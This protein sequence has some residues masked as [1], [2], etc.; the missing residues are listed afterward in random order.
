MVAQKHILLI[1]S[2]SIAAYKSLELI[3][4]LRDSGVRCTCV[5]T[6]GG[7]Q[8]VTPLSVASL[9]GQPVY[10]DLFSLKDETEM[11]H[12]R[13]SREADL[14]V[15]APASAD[16]LARMTQGMAHDL[17][18]TLLLA[19][20]KPVVAVP[21]M[22]T[23]MWH[24]PATQRNV[25]QLQQDGIHFIGPVS[26]DLA[27]GET[28]L[29]R[30]AE[31]PTIAQ[32]LLALLGH[33]NPQAQPLAGR[34]ALVTAGPTHEPID[35]V[36]FIGNH[37][38]GKQGYAIAE[39]LA[40]AGALVTLISGPTSLPC[41]PNVSR[42]LV[43]TAAE[44]LDACENSL[45]ADIFVGAA[46][47]ADWT[48]QQAHSQKLKKRQNQEAPSL[49][50]KETKDILKHISQLKKHRP[51]LVIGF[52]AETLEGEALLQEAAKKRL[53][54][55]CDWLVANNVKGGALFGSDRTEATLITPEETIH[56]P[57]SSKHELA[58]LL[59]ERIIFALSIPSK[60]L[61][62]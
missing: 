53:T 54:K 44:M 58:V 59:T 60:E 52:A 45:P 4:L 32:E 25:R 20:D 9:S 19:T 42:S 47:V 33:S 41:P 5:I 40:N 10:T 23:H 61:S 31:V 27:C 36:R 56:F 22:N 51:R 62:A 21:A 35:P 39:A 30:M 13:L 26:G 1:I 48:P 46:A 43:S 17:A 18:T 3:R 7:Q 55:G 37:S 50:L 8:F 16:L 49:T 14:V 38:S 12:I 57:P 24:H 29:G 28:G 11:G 2:G 6:E 34:S 15:I